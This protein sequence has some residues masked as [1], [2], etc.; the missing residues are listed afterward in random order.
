MLFGHRWARLSSR[1]SPICAAAASGLCFNRLRSFRRFRRWKCRADAAHRRVYRGRRA[2]AM[3]SLEIVGLAAWAITGPGA[4]RRPAAT[5]AIARAWPPA[6][7]D[8]GRR[9]NRRAR[10]RH[11][12]A[13]LCALSLHRRQGKRHRHHGHAR[14]MIEEY[15]HIIFELDDGQVKA[16]RRPAA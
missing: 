11:R 6:R 4:F 8:P 12:P 13:N 7:P 2:R 1:A 10:Q 5:R 3:R 16:M 15:A 14:P 9:A